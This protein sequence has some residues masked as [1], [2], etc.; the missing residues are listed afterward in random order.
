[1]FCSFADLNQFTF[2]NNDVRRIDGEA[3][4]MNVNGRI[5]IEH[6]NFL[7]ISY[8]AFVGKENRLLSF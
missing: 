7:N 6:N 5:L 8:Q 3:F 4:Q 2:S 1:M